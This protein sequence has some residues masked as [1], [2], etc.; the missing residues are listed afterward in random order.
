MLVLDEQ[1]QDSVALLTR[2]LIDPDNGRILGFFVR[3]FVGSSGPY[4]LLTLDILS[5]GTK[6]HI[7]CADKLSPPDELLRLREHLNDSRFFLGQKIRIHGSGVRVGSCADIQFDT[8]HFQI[9]WLFPRGLFFSKQPIAVA[10]IVE[11]TEEAIW[12]KDPLR[13]RK[14]SMQKEQKERTGSL[15][16]DIAPS[17]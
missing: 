1:T 8:R 17:M 3:M 15:I 4:F 9:E 13:V 5:V 16:P 12:V 11:V 6:V 7:R 2:P 10:D 14:E